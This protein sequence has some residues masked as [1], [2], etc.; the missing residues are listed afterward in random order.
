MNIAHC[1][2]KTAFDAKVTN[3]WNILKNLH[4]LERRTGSIAK[5]NTDY[6]F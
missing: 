4:K 2:P 6:F 1:H 5:D 3:I